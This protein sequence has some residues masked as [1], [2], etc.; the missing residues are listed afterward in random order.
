MTN[1]PH[2][3]RSTFA[4]SIK[5]L[6]L[7]KYCQKYS[8]R[9]MQCEYKW[10]IARAEVD[11]PLDEYARKATTRKDWKRIVKWV[12]TPK[13]CCNPRVCMYHPPT[14]YVKTVTTTKKKIKP[15]EEQHILNNINVTKYYKNKTHRGRASYILD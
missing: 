14:Q 4:S 13:W 10:K 1:Q 6:S 9:A 2:D 11:V 3:R 5:K 15:R 12:T 7:F 8:Y